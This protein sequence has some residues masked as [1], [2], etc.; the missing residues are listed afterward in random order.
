VDENTRQPAPSG[1]VPNVGRPAA[2]DPAEPPWSQVIAA[3][4][5]VWVRRRRSIG[6]GPRR[7]SG[8]EPDR[9]RPGSHLTKPTA[10]RWRLAAAVVALAAI[11]VAALQFA[12]VFTGSG[13]PAA[14]TSLPGNPATS[15]VGQGGGLSA[16]AA[17]Q[18]EAARWIS[19]QVSADAI[20]ACDPAMCAALQEQGVA[21]GR[22]MPLQAGA[23][24]PHG[25]AVMV[26]SGMAG[27]QLASQY[28]PAVVASFGTGSARVDVRATEP[29]GP[30]GYESALRADLAARQSA[31]SQLLRNGHIQSTAREAAQLLAGE[32]DSRLLVTLASLASQYAFRVT[33][34]GDTSPGVQVLFRGVIITSDSNR[35]G[36]AELGNMMALVNQQHPPYLPTRAAIIH[37]AA[38]QAALDIE[39]AAPSPLGL[40]TAYLVA[41][42]Q[43][44]AH[45]TAIADGR[46]QPY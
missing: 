4:A 26:T 17:V 31:G 7:T 32:V 35:P 23:V 20:V 39:F 8:G 18:A 44:T 2:R 38:G 42:S 5:K 15:T 46:H 16:A 27:S 43:P 40:L 6:F 33:A 11:A 3:T 1:L 24:N 45:A 25:A 34:F 21:A 30:A 19:G 41:D 12:G 14:R 29:G 28:A 13:A 36:A 37:T 9:D 22:L 10:S